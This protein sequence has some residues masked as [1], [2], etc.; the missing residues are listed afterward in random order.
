MYCY[1]KGVNIVAMDVSII[2]SNDIIYGKPPFN[3][4][5]NYPELSHYIFDTC[6]DGLVYDN[7]RKM[8]INLRLDE[9]NIGTNR[10]NPFSEF[11]SKGDNVVIKPNF[12]L[13]NNGGIPDIDAVVT[14][15]AV[16]RPI[17]D[18]SLLA[19][20]GT[21]KITIA[22][23]PQ[24]NADFDKVVERNGVKDLVDY[25]KSKGITIE[26][27]DLRKNR[28]IGGFDTGLREELLGDPAGYVLCNLSER[29]FLND[30]NNVDQLY[31]AD[32][33]RKFIVKQHTSGHNYLF[34]KTILNAN[35]VI[36]VPKL[37]THRKAG[38]TIN[39]KNMVGANG[40]KNYLAHFRVG[41]PAQGGDE[42]SNEVPFIGKIHYKWLRFA[43]DHILIKNTRKSRLLYKYL[44]LP[45]RFTH[46][47]YKKLYGK[48]YFMGSGDWHGNDTVWRMCLDLNQILLYSDNEG[49]IHDQMQRKYF[50]IVDGIVAGEGDGPLEPTAKHVGYLA[51][52]LNPFLV[53]YVCAYNMG[54]C[55][56]KIPVIYNAKKSNQFAYSVDADN[57]ICVVNDTTTNYKELNMKFEPQKNWKGYIER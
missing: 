2:K 16:L 36:N 20:G 15:A 24:A 52:G 14:N 25:Y 1:G 6:N 32:Y 26:L 11:I 57:I 13:D 44:S 4:I 34:S 40:D 19:L 47:I 51:C 35:V 10:W 17:I 43:A 37:K 30:I 41:S 27:Y 28:Y 55:P 23:A 33:D 39:S 45:F 18:Y 50:C 22:D 8:L 29:S 38:V 48:D 54:F 21:G 31:G 7:V 49:V 53:D 56:E 46:H 3:P 9:L 12:V 5:L 42:F